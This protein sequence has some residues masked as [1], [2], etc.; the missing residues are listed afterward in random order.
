MPANIT[1]KMD[2]A[3][4]D[5]ITTM[6]AEFPNSAKKVRVRAVNK[7]LTGVR[8]D[9]TNAIS[10]EVTATKTAIRSTFGLLK[11]N[12]SD[13]RGII[14]SKGAPLPLIAY[15]ARQ[16]NKG[17]TAQ[18]DRTDARVLWPSAFISTVRTAQQAASGIEG[19]KG[20]FSRKKPPYKTK[21]SPS[22]PW[23]R[24][25]RPELRLPIK[26]MYGPSIP[27]VF[28]R[29]TAMKK[30][31]ASAD[32]RLQKNVDHELDYEL[33]KLGLGQTSDWNIE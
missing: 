19:H 17:V 23:K 32:E 1:I 15:S 10:D 4:L 6:L 13:E 30:S 11:S 24:F 26:E 25:G 14:Y 29:E 7:T 8:T 33:E 3:E 28:A 21:A 2:Q 12:Y 22:L 31:L 16:T 20:V 18:I 5:K 9:A 27:N